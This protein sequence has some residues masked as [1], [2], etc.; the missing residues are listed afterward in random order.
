MNESI[1]RALMRL[2]AI[3]S[4]IKKNGQSDNKR[5]IVMDYL[6]QQYS[7]EIVQKYINF[8]DE[9][10]KYFHQLNN[11]PIISN[12]D[13]RK[14]NAQSRIIE[15]C[16]QINEELEHKQK[17]IVLVYLLD[18]IHSGERLTR[19]E[20]SLVRTAASFLK[21]SDDE[22]R[23]AKHFTFEE[24][25]DIV[26]R[27]WLLVIRPKDATTSDIKQLGIDKLEGQILVLHIP[28]ADVYVFRYYG[29]M[30]LVLNGHRIHSGRSYIWS[31]GSVIRSPKIGSIYFS[32]VRGK[33]IH[34]MAEVK[35]IF[36]AEDIE[37]NYFNSRNGVKRFNL[38]EESGRLVGIIGGSGSGKSTLL[39]VLN[40]NLKPRHGS[41]RINGYDIHKDKESVKGIIGY[42]PQDDLLIK[43]LTVYENLYYNAKLCFDSYTEEE[44]ADVVEDALIDFDLLEARDLNV[45]DAFTTFLSGGQRKRLNI[46]LELI[47]EPWI[48]F[49]DEP[50]S[51]LS[52][53]DSEKVIT[54]LKRQTL[55]G[56]LIIANIHQPSSDVFR[57]I[58]K[59]L[60]MDQGGRVIYYGH[61]MSAITYF[62]QEAHYPDAEETECLSCG[63]INSDEILRI[64]EAR[65][66]DA[67]GRLTRKRKTSPEEWYQRFL[68]KIDTQ[69]K[70]IVREH[71]A[72][73]PK[74]N[75]RIPDHFN[76]FLIFLKRD[77]LAKYYN[78][79]YLMLLA[80][81]APILGFILAFFS[82]NYTFV[83]GMPK[84]IFGENQVIPA[85]LF[86]AVIVALFLGLVISAEEIFKDRKILRREKFLNLS[87]SSY[88]FSKIIILFGI[89]ALQSL[90]FVLI[91][92]SMLEIRG[93]LFSY[94]V[95]LFTAACWSNML[96]LN[97]S[98]GF[99]SV[100]TIYILVPLILV[101]QL[102]FSGVVVDFSKMHNKI[103]NDKQVPIIGDL[104]TSRWAYEALAVTQFKDNLYERYFFDAESRAN[105]AGY[106]RSYAITGL[107]ELLDDSEDLYFNNSDTFRF[108]N[109]LNVLK[110]ELKRIC[111]D[112]GTPLP[113]FSD[114]L[115]RKSYKPSLNKSYNEILNKAL[116]IYKNRYN[117]AVT[118]RDR[119]YE[120][121]IEKLGGED[122]FLTFKKKYFN[123]QLAAVLT[124]EKE[125]MHYTIHDGEMIP[126]KDAIYREPA[127][128]SWRAHFYAPHKDFFNYYVA[129][130]WFNLCVIWLFT[131]L[132]FVLLYYDVMRRALTY[133]ET[134]R[135]NRLNKI[136]LNRLLK[137]ADLSVNIRTKR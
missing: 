42:V 108:N 31:V 112:I 65:E 7:R 76:Q 24:I 83:N 86:M 67:N 109:N 111:H 93:M 88:L 104:M 9:Q 69:T 33:F 30:K 51:G 72:Q 20:V 6:D 55:K 96:G 135:I 48:L 80:L 129:T 110:S 53:A 22:F 61:P 38:T 85:F 1:L 114:S 70:L 43:E 4:D 14:K 131:G 49:V 133:M 120:E 40:G 127:N 39:N 95:V 115:D 77:L 137:I 128:N 66:V 84:Y 32:W 100:V 136:K 3:V 119:I 57:M 103:S 123:K 122:N 91:G 105:S 82:K 19:L 134:L 74:N 92:N 58:D 37:F 11:D 23:D 113:S 26:N 78:K 47:R 44:I 98:S 50:T 73:V 102:L 107:Q 106:Y 59:L 75:F 34:A 62:K 101:P 117:N 79:Q 18:F 15:L 2:F 17:I 27:D 118:E 126:I 87:R 41:I 116:R 132:L 12:P 60:V 90:I 63:N 25:N 28:S 21:I 89:S 81:E 71:D 36:T 94:W 121:L 8:F 10:V 68:T 56:K 29:N 125:I 45:G 124:N 54:L 97:I 5:S 35:F 130:F 99:N 52:S 13:D 64:V 46:A 16:T